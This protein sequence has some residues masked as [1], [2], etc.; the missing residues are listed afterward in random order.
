[1]TRADG[2]RIAAIPPSLAARMRNA[3]A[4]AA[5][6]PAQAADAPDV[7][8]LRA[9]GGA[10]LPRLLH[11][12]S[13]LTPLDVFARLFLYGVT[14][15]ERHAR[16]AF[17]D[18]ALEEWRD[19]GLI[20]CAG[21]EAV[22]LVAIYP[23][24]GLLLAFDKPELVERGTDSDHV[25]G[26]TNSTASL[27]AFRT[28]EPRRSILD[29]GAGCGVLGFLAARSGGH[30]LLTDVNPRAIQFAMFN[31]RLN[32]IDD[33]EFAVG[34]AFEPAQG[35]KFDLILSNPPCV[36]GPAARYAYR[37]S[38][39]E[40]DG[41]CRRIVAAAP[42]HLEDGGLFQCTAE[43]PNLGA[44]WE[45][46]PAE[47]LRG[48]SCDALVLLV[49]NCGAVQHCEETVCDTDVLERAEQTRLYAEFAAYF[50][51]RGVDSISE[52][53][54]ALRRRS[55]A[56]N[57]TRYEALRGRR[58]APFG[59]AVARYFS[60]SDELERLGAALLDARPRLAPGVSLSIARA[61]SRDGWSEEN[62]TLRQDG[63]FE[64]QAAVDRRI[65]ELIRGCDGGRTV[66]QLGAE[67][68][69]EAGYR[70]ETIAPGCL[71][72]V[73]QMLRRGFLTL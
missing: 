57:W 24:D 16:A 43:W 4:A 28:R 68:A 67:M 2:A 62:Y 59:D 44:G 37:D 69:E 30:L 54:L 42:E 41:L 23:Y 63:G 66:R 5:F 18:P 53:L 14:V 36:L 8:E 3:M 70:F 13:S 34:D 9:R 29:L 39:L 40:M 48:I 20:A 50:A 1:L 31:A 60:T 12:T 47:W 64:F 45:E 58:A 25:C 27:A 19:A 38:G 26:L 56:K 61:W 17:V 33:V 52:G 65:A 21:G 55:G 11:A 6:L 73:G 7:L 32:G 46:R 71:E 10:N 22:G 15:S 35:R 51:A 72:V 49:Q